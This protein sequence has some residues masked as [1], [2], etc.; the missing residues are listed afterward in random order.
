MRLENSPHS[1]SRLVIRTASMC[2]ARERERER[3]RASHPTQPKIMLR[4]RGYGH[5]YLSQ[6]NINYSSK[7]KGV[8]STVGYKR[9][10][11]SHPWTRHCLSMRTPA[12]V[13]LE[14]THIR[15]AQTASL[16]GCTSHWNYHLA[17][18]A[19]NGGT[20]VLVRDGLHCCMVPSQSTMLAV[21]LQLC[22]AFCSLYLP[23]H[24]SVTVADLQVLLF[25]SLI[26]FYFRETWM[27]GTTSAAAQTGTE[28]G[29]ALETLVFRFN[30]VAL[31]TR[32]S[33]SWQPPLT[34]SSAVSPF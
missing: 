30:V 29:R 1:N 27:R 26:L 9:L 34:L 23:P 8:A 18:D 28:R 16:R 14:E 10:M 5:N 4:L 25:T 31:N 33:R 3:E 22:T 24:T 6:E 11:L 12:A 13:C 21:A 19:A 20:A 7:S 32:I 15:H 17:G 2:T